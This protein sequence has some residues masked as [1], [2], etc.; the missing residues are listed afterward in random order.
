[1]HGL[2][3]TLANVIPGLA[4]AE[5]AWPYLGKVV[6]GPT[7]SR[8]FDDPALMGWYEPG[9]PV[10]VYAGACDGLRRLALP[11]LWS[12]SKVGVTTCALHHRLRYIGR[13][14]YGSRYRC[15]DGRLVTEDGFVEW[16]AQP[17]EVS[18]ALSPSSP[19]QVGVR[20]IRVLL[21]A[22]LVPRVF[23][24]MLS[25]ALSVIALDRVMATVAGQ[26]RA[27]LFGVD[28]A[29]YRR[30]TVYD[31]AG[32]TR[33]SRARELAF[34]RPRLDGDVLVAIIEA[35]LAAHLEEIAAAAGMVRAAA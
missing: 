29:R 12:I 14:R 11:G 33:T 25:K 24:D 19:I 31:F 30:A 16:M 8:A 1:M 21:P 22:T 15:D 27:T 7:A 32:S 17:I 18:L 2:L 4:S 10:T 20:G 13:D 9:Q 34:F 5:A 26:A 28:P 23:D 35:L 6:P 3:N